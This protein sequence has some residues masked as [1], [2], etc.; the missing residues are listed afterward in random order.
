MKIL[1]CKF[2]EHLQSQIEKFGILIQIQIFLVLL[3]H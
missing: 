3:L 1:K 2:Q